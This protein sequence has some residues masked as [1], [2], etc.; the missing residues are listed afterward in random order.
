MVEA[1][2]TSLPGGPSGLSLGDVTTP[3]HVGVT[4]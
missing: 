1:E 2:M 3:G 4:S